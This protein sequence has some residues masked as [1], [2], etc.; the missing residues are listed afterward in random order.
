MT[1]FLF[2]FF[3]SEK[4]SLDISSEST[5][6]QMI[7]MK[8][9]HFSLKKKIKM[10]SAAVLIG[11]LRV[12]EIVFL[13]STPCAPKPHIV[14]GSYQFPLQFLLSFLNSNN[15]NQPLS[16]LSPE[17]VS[18]KLVMK[19]QALF[20]VNEISSPSFCRNYFKMSSAVGMLKVNIKQYRKL[21]W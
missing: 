16:R 9:R 10:L 21:Y 4:I 3:F 11:I 17:Q 12:K 7:H 6:W 8:C 15:I 13:D 1:I 20:P 14:I 2:F 5:A 19:C 18:A